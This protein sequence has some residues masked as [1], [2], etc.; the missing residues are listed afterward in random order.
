MKRF[1]SKKIKKK[2]KIYVYLFTFFFV[3]SYI[4]VMFYLSK[5]KLSN[6][7][8]DSNINY[9]NFSFVNFLSDKTTEIINKPVSLLDVNVRNASYKSGKKT[10]SSLNK[11]EVKKVDAVK[12]FNPV[13]YVYNTHQGENYTD[14]TVLDAAS[15]LTEKLNDSGLDTFFEEQSVTTF[16][17]T[18]NM[19]YYKSY[20]VSRKYLEEAKEKYP[21]IVYFFDI[22]RDAL[23][24]EKST[25]T[26]GNK[27]YAKIMFI[28]GTDNKAYEANLNNAD[29]LNDMINNMVPGI[30]RGV[31]KKGG[32]GV[33]GVYNQDVSTNSFLIEVGGNNNNKEEVINTINVIIKAITEY[34]RGVV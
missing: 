32:S 22:H 25:V 19:K 23:S 21:S 29:K 6:K 17:Q 20:L 31:I 33:N 30:T 13:I 1:K 14:Y 34:V 8:L 2:K 16:L 15:Y 11:D 7:V 4:F 18:N 24:K 5:N 27:K 10:D 26:V 3:F 9:V 28:V 12:N